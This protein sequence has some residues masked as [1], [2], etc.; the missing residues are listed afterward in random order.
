MRSGCLRRSARHNHHLVRCIPLG[1]SFRTHDVQGRFTLNDP[2]PS[3]QAP[4]RTS[5]APPTLK[6][7]SI[8]PS[9]IIDEVTVL[10]WLYTGG[11]L[12]KATV[13]S[14]GLNPSVHR[15]TSH[16]AVQ[17]L[18]GNS[19]RGLRRR[20]HHNRY[21]GHHMLLGRLTRVCIAGD[22][23]PILPT[24]QNAIG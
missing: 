19:S 3:R 22:S 14:T 15:P 23:S 10:P 21:P 5:R 18:V 7:S 20:I 1:I 12:S 11:A 13:S 17:C 8:V 9:I 16:T 2:T 6:V 4:S 24:H